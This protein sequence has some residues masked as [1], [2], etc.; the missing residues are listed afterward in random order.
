MLVSVVMSSQISLFLH[1][2]LQGVIFGESFQ[3][4]LISIKSI[5]WLNGSFFFGGVNVELYERGSQDLSNGA[6]VTSEL[7]NFFCLHI[8][9]LWNSWV[10]RDIYADLPVIC[11][12][13][14]C[15]FVEGRHKVS[16]CL[17]R[18]VLQ[19]V[20]LPGIVER[21]PSWTA[22]ICFFQIESCGDMVLDLLIERKW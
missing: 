7:A 16:H 22:S 1:F 3:K 13:H 21:F 4:N 5:S 2:A 18:Q 20:S 6:Y 9:S 17:R 15:G 14:I 8:Y 12:E 11:R 10:W 19:V